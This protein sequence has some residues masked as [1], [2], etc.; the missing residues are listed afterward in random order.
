[1]AVQIRH[2]IPERRSLCSY[3]FLERS[4]KYCAITAVFL[5]IAVSLPGTPPNEQVN[6]SCLFLFATETEEADRIRSIVIEELTREMEK[7]G[8][9][10]IPEQTWRAELLQEELSSLELLQ[11][12][13]LVPLAQRVEADIAL[14]GSIRIESQA[15]ILRIRGYDV[16]ANNLVFSKEIREAVNIGIYNTISSLSREL[17]DT[18]LEWAESQPGKTALSQSETSIH[19]SEMNERGSPELKS[20]STARILESDA[21]P[22]EDPNEAPIQD[23]GELAEDEMGGGP[24]VLGQPA[25]RKDTKVQITLLSNDEGAWVYLGPDQRLGTIESGKL[26]IEVPANTQLTIE[27][28]KTGYHTNREHFQINGQSTGI[29]LRPMFRKTRFGFEL[30]STSSQ[31]LGI[32]AGFRIYIVPDFIMFRADDYIYFS[33]DSEGND[34]FSAFHNDFR[35]QFGSYLFTPPS[36]RVRFGVAT[37]IGIILS[38]LGKSYTQSENSTFYDFYWDVVDLWIDLNWQKGAVFLKVETKYALGLGVCLL[39]QGFLTDYGTQFTIG[40]LLKL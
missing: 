8:F 11:S 15:I 31:L 22:S 29:R 4:V 24:V 3:V 12:S 34:S 36:R 21:P 7:W 38:T 9:T 18:F 20:P 30:F 2:A 25:D 19:E 13:A 40:W 39:D 5:L 6:K 26:V 1:M 37:G 35:I 17:V 33:V 23:E 10:I 28:V 32:G 27:T 16:I 14:V